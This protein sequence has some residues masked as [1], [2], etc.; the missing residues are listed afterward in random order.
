MEF[1]FAKNQLDQYMEYKKQV[2]KEL[3]KIKKK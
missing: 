2:N 3:E 1:N